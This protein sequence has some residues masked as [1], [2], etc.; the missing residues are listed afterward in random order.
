MVFREVERFLLIRYHTKHLLRNGIYNSLLTSLLR[1][2][3]ILGR[4][5]LVGSLVHQAQVSKDLNDSDVFKNIIVIY[6]PGLISTSFCPGLD[7]SLPRLLNSLINSGLHFR[8][9][10]WFSKLCTQW[11]SKSFRASVIPCCSLGIRLPTHLLSPRVSPIYP[12]VYWLTL[13][14]FLHVH[15]P[16]PVLFNVNG[17][18]SVTLNINMYL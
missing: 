8:Y 6:S 7:Y 1:L 2:L 12:I 9:L 16:L 15:H 13:P 3:C 10:V 18:F 4:D 11:G 14:N 17:Q 5:R